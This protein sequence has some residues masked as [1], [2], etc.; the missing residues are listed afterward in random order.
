MH[1][2]PPRQVAAAIASTALAAWPF[3]A[4]AQ[5]SSGLPAERVRAELQNAG[6]VADQPM[7]WSSSGLTTFFVQDPAERASPNPRVVMVLVYPDVAAAEAAHLQAHADAEAAQARTLP[8]SDNFGPLM[9]PGYGP[10]A[11]RGN[12]A[13]VE[14]TFADL[15]RMYSS[16]YEGYY[17]NVNDGVDS[18]LATHVP[19]MAVDF[20]ILNA[21]TSFTVNA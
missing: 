11:W 15:A 19:T 7:H 17:A 3:I 14:S 9:I 12:V 1:Y 8:Y 20:D 5:P 2:C 4:G 16:E 6:Y 10:S 13:M 18:R 21:L